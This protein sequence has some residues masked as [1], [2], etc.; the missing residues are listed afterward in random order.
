[1]Y[2]AGNDR[3]LYEITKPPDRRINILG[4]DHLLVVVKGDPF[5]LTLSRRL[6]HLV[7]RDAEHRNPPIVGRIELR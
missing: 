4:I 7:V 2:L 5:F 3:C 6:V 1:M